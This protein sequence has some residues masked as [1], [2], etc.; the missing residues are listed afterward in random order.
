MDNIAAE[1]VKDG[2][3]VVKYSVY[4]EIRYVSCGCNGCTRPFLF[5]EKLSAQLSSK[6]A[7]FGTR[8]PELGETAT[9]SISNI[10]EVTQ[11]YPS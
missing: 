10:I 1:S 9:T 8:H 4:V 5:C 2:A 3:Q 7:Y 11:R 6:P